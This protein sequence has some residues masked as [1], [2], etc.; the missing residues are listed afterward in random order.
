MSALRELQ[1]GFARAIFEGRT[2]E[3]VPRVRSG[4]LAADE[5]VQV[6]RNNAFASLTR[7]LA[8]VYPVVARLVGERYFAQ[9]ARAYVRAHPP[10]SGNLHDFGRAVAL[11]VGGL[12]E[13]S[14][15]PYLADVATLEW[16]YH[17]T[18]HAADAPPLDLARLA[19]VAETEHG[20]L[21][22]KL[23]PATR[24]VASRYPIYA[25]WAANQD[26]ADCESTI[27]LD[28]GP[29]YLMVARRGLETF[30]ARVAPGD[31]ALAAEI[32]AGATLAQ[33]CDAA[34][35]ADP[36]IDLGAAFGRLVAS[37]TVAGFHHF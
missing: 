12:H 16:A 36:A 37:G 29:D 9:L 31:F 11:F 33:A 28:A 3:I 26:D 10:R 20:R 1:L 18:F 2:D 22:F 32:S 21:R 27:E 14:D 8:D 19:E 25:I 6:Y 13:A 15:L 24:L 4:R 35:A 23:H 17:H 5:R 7:A 30:V 34:L